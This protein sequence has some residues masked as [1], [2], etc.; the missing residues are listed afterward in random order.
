MENYEEFCSRSLAKLQLEEKEGMMRCPPP[1]QWP[2]SSV[3]RIRGKTILSP[4]LS[5]E[6]RMEMCMYRQKAVEREAQREALCRSSLITQVQNILDNAQKRNVL[7]QSEAPDSPEDHSPENEQ[8]VGS[9]EPDSLLEGRPEGLDTD[10][11]WQTEPTSPPLQLGD[12]EVRVEEQDEDGEEEEEE[13]SLQSLLRRSRQYMEREQ[14]RG[15]SKVGCSVANVARSPTQA[16]AGA[17]IG[18]G[19]ESLSDKENENGSLVAEA[20]QCQNHVPIARSPVQLE[21]QRQSPTGAEPRSPAE[22]VPSG[23]CGRFCQPEPTLSLSPIP[24]PHRGRPRPVSTGDILFSLPVEV[25]VGRP[26]EIGGASW[27][28][29]DQRSPDHTSSASSLAPSLASSRRASHTGSSPV[30]EK[31]GL[32]ILGVMGGGGGGAAGPSLAGGPEGFRR[33]SQTLDS[34]SGRPVDRSQERL[35]RFMAGVAQVHSTRRSPP[36]PP[37]PLHGQESPVPALLRTQAT[38]DPVTSQVRR[39]LDSE[40][41]HEGRL[42][43]SLL[44]TP[45]EEKRTDSVDAVQRRVQALEE[46][47]AFQLSLLLAEQ[48]REQQRLRQG[49]DSQERCLSGVC[50]EGGVEWR[51]AR[52]P[53]PACSPAERSPP[54]GSYSMGLPSPVSPSVATPS[55]PPAYPW[56]SSRIS[57]KPRSRLSQVLTVEQ[58]RA[59]CRL[60]AIVRGFLVRRL[61]K[62]EKV[63][64]LR[65][66]VQDTQE[67][68]R[69]FQTEVPPRRTSLSP[70]DLSLQERVRAQLRAALFDIH[71]V[72]F[73]LGL[74]ER[75]ALLQQDRELRT[76]RK[77]RDMEKAKAPKERRCLS[78]ATQKSLDRKKQRVGESPGP[79]RKTQQKPKS[80]TTNRI[81]QPSQGQNAPSPGHLYRQGSWYKKTPEERVKR[82]N[83][84]KKQNSLG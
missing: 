41:D 60:T 9:P 8:I 12:V 17:T 68:I 55:T 32:P 44:S 19:I 29:M 30:H 80:P 57:T 78:A 39:R 51:G 62:T 81:L 42:T 58:Q 43:P 4:Q 47:H 18:V 38:P 71:D 76:E 46:E 5:E 54:Q 79:V 24:R 70:Q 23:P 49:L 37:Y 16:G 69:S 31:A 33:R 2:Q 15:G 61:L 59:L 20:T 82:S 34:Q 84:L 53:Y 48:D 21:G 45:V 35:P 14:G 56:G 3:I 73:E 67:F 26:R 52:E 22:S 50:L 72:F 75:L 74:E 66:T 25:G 63:K 7:H 36:G 64:H 40:S 28:T 27:L 6:E 1:G 77:L 11:T 10:A 83:S 13:M 65:Q